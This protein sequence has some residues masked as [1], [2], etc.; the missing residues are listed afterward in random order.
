MRF[1]LGLLVCL[2]WLGTAVTASAQGGFQGGV[3]GGLNGAKV[4][5]EPSESS[6]DWRMGAT[7]GGFVRGR[8]T[9]LLGLQVEALYSMNGGT[10]QEIVIFETFDQTLKLDYVQVPVL[11]H[12]RGAQR[13]AASLLAYIGPYFGFRTRAELEAFDTT[14]DQKDE[15]KSN[16][17][18]LVIG[19]GADISGIQIELRYSHGFTNIATDVLQAQGISTAHNRAVALIG[20][21]TLFG[22]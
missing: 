8:L 21:I 12:L 4:T 14:Q 15:F 19:A 3:K 13:G 7:I 9:E 16:D 22:R 17:V 20:G 1:R 6:S 5:A 10:D 11:L 18:G 2:V